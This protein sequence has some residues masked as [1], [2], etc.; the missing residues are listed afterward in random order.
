[1][2]SNS[3]I[4]ANTNNEIDQTLAVGQVLWEGFDIH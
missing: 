3:S 4:V 2:R 1:M